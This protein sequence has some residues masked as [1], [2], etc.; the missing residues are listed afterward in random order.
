MI[1]TTL[2]SALRRD[3]APRPSAAT[4][5]GVA[6][7]TARRRKERTY[8]EPCGSSRPVL[9][10]WCWRARSQDVGLQKLVTFLWL[11]AEAKSR[12]EPSLLRRRAESAWRL[13]WT[14]MLSCA[15]TRAFACSLLD[16]RNNGGGDGVIPT[17]ADVLREH[18]HAGL[19]VCYLGQ[20]PLRPTLIAT[21]PIAT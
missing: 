18:R 1:D 15:A 2:V 4:T 14:S 6:L 5:D 13:R 17:L 9:S 16:R 3:G 20:L 11:L 10:W 12:S 7:Q 8:P 19:G 21:W